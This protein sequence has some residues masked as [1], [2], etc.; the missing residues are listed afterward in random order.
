MHCG[1]DHLE[2]FYSRVE[3]REPDID[4]QEQ[5]RGLGGSYL[6]EKIE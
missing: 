6:D 1:F 4:Q 3:P 2:D 5:R